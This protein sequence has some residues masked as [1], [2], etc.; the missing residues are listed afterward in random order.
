MN[1]FLLINK[2]L[3]FCHHTCTLGSS[4]FS[5]LYLQLIQPLRILIAVL[6]NRLMSELQF[7]RPVEYQEY[8]LGIVPLFEYQAHSLHDMGHRPLIVV[9]RLGILQNQGHG[10]KYLY[11]CKNDSMFFD[12]LIADRSFLRYTILNDP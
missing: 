8:D 9:V 4:A 11:R 12:H 6:S 1:H 5:L 3:K 7:E 10:S 2:T